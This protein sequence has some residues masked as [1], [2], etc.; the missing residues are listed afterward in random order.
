MSRDETVLVAAPDRGLRQRASGVLHREGFDVIEAG[1]GFQ[2]VILAR[3]H[4]PDL[5]LLAEVMPGELDAVRTARLL[6]SDPLTRDVRIL[7]MAEKTGSRARKLWAA[8]GVDDYLTLPLN[9][10]EL[11]RKARPGPGRR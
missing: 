8:A 2:A 6:R 3:T 1:H 11:V 5:A 4:A 9:E 10:G 7:V